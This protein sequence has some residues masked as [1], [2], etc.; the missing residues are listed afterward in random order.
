MATQD[1]IAVV[2]DFDETLAPDATTRFLAGRGVDT[3]AFWARDVKALVE[4]GYDPTLAW[5]GLFLDLVGPDKPLGHVSR[6][7]LEEFGRTIDE[8]LF[9]GAAELPGDLRRAVADFRDTSVELHIVSGGLRDLMSGSA[10]VRDEFQSLYACELDED[11]EGS[12][13]RIKRCVTF[14]EKTRY[15]FEINKGIDPHEG[16]SNP[17]LVNRPVGEAA[18][19]VPLANMI[20]VGDGLTDIPCFSLITKS[21]GYAFGVFDASQESKARRALAEF[22]RPKRV[23]SMHSPRYGPTDDL[24]AMIRAAVVSIATSLEIRRKDAY[25]GR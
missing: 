20:Y 13:A 2:F 9:P 25:E 8:T 4:R 16:A 12:V 18:R 22:L 10:F 21:G 24:G 5:L 23:T 7:D 6:S 3:E 11:E 19:R 14:T 17:Y 1:I 15:L